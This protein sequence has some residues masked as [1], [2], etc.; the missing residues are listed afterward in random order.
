MTIALFASVPLPYRPRPDSAMTGRRL[1]T[2]WVE[3]EEKETEVRHPLLSLEA[4]SK[5]F[6][7]CFSGGEEALSLFSKLRVT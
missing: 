6:L 2:Q 1:H 5:T 4:V 3:L 7:F